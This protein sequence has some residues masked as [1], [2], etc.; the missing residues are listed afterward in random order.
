MI[1]NE[2]GTNKLSLGSSEKVVKPAAVT[3]SVT[4]S[5][6]SSKKFIISPQP[7][8][9]MITEDTDKSAATS[10]AEKLNGSSFVVMNPE[11]WQ[12]ISEGLKT[13]A[14]EFKTFE[15]KYSQQDDLMAE[16]DKELPALDQKLTA[17]LQAYN[18]NKIAVDAKANALAGEMNT[19][20]Q[21]QT[22]V[23]GSINTFKAYGGRINAIETSN[24]QMQREIETLKT[25]V[26]NDQTNKLDELLDKVGNVFIN[27]LDHMPAT[28][29][30]HV[31][32]SSAGD[33]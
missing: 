29:A 13:I 1:T 22:T 9:T 18:N 2:I 26:M 5:D 24:T 16:L 7:T 32:E 15:E 11:Q 25:T 33:M 14:K 10:I 3:S 20:N 28:E 23:N 21:W 30:N 8:S 17:H 31:V 27:F 6:D 19:L 4:S 12:E